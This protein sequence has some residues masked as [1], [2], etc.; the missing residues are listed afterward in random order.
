MNVGRK[1]RQV[2]KTAAYTINPAVDRDDS[3]FT[4][5]GAVGAVTFTLPTANERMNGVSYY[6]VSIAAQSIV[7][8][9]PVLDTALEHADAAADSLTITTQGGE[10]KAT[11]VNTAPVGSPPVYRWFIRGTSL[12][13]TVT[14]QT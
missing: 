1:Q 8:A 11:G 12:L 9:A 7:I 5:A 10:A 6:F 4:N 2:N 14:V 13:S 3:I